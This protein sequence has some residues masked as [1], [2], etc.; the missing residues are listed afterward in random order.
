MSAG[1]PRDPRISRQV[2]QVRELL[3]K[4]PKLT[5]AKACEQVGIRPATY[6][7]RVEDGELETAA[8]PDRLRETPE[9]GEIPVIE[10]DYSSQESHRIYPMGD[11]HIGSAEHQSERLDEWLDYVLQAPDASLAFTGDGLNS[12]IKTSVSETYDEVAPVGQAKRI[13]RRKLKPL[14]EAGRIDVGVP[15]NHEDRIYKAVGDCPIEDIADALE[16]PYVPAAAV[17]R[18]HVGDVTYDL[19]LRHGTGGGGTAG[20]AVNRLE[21]Q[22]KIIDADIYLSAHTHNQVAFVKDHFFVVEEDGEIET[23]RKKRLFVCSGS[24]LAYEKYA[25]KAGYSPA[26]IGA[27]RIYL[28]GRVKDAHASV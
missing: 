3:R 19:F 27:P 28:D 15:G 10:R 11:F 23:R 7:Y 22:E 18:Y 4:D 21:K 6:R 17:L 5:R 14:A 25:A 20:A 26:H 9:G 8:A 12:A 2:E 24:F 1:R 16:F 13:L